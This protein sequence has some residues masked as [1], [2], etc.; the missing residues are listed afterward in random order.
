MTVI[1]LS[2][3]S[4]STVSLLTLG[5]LFAIG[6]FLGISQAISLRAAPASAAEPNADTAAERTADNR[7]KSPTGPI[8]P[9]D[10]LKYLELHPALKAELIASEQTVID[11]VAIDFDEE[12]TVEVGEMRDYP[13]GPSD[14]NAAPL[15]KIKTLTDKDGDGVYET[16]VDFAVELP[17]VTGIQPWRG[18]VI[19]TYAGTVAYLRDE[20]GDGRADVHIPRF[21]GLPAENSQRRANHPKL[22]LDNQIYIANGLRGGSVIAVRPE[23][24]QEAKEVSI[25]GM[26][27]RF[28]PLTGKYEAIS[29]V[30]QFGLTFDDFG[31]RFVCS[32]RNPNKHIV[33]EDRY[34]KRNPFLAVGAV[35]YD[36]SPAGDASRVFPIADRWITS[37]LHAGQFTSACG[38][39]I[40]RGNLLPEEFRGNSFTCEA[41]GSLMHR[42][43]LSPMGATFTSHTGRDGIEFLASRDTWFRSV[44]SADGPDG[45]FYVVDMYRAV[46]EHPQFMPDELK[47]RPDLR[48]GDDR[49]RLYRL[50]PKDAP[51]YRD[52]PQ[53]KL[54]DKA[55]PE[56]LVAAYE[57]PNGWHRST[58]AR[59]L[60]EQLPAS[61]VAPL[62]KMV[63]EGTRP[64]A[65]AQALWTLKALDGLSDELLLKALGDSNLRVAE[66]AVLLSEPHLATNP[67][68]LAAV[69]SLGS[70][71]D[72][73]LRFQV[74]LSLGQAPVTDETLQTLASI[75][76]QPDA[77]S[78]TQSAVLS[79]V[80]DQPHQ[81][82][83]VI[84]RTPPGKARSAM[85][86]RLCEV[87]GAR[88]NADGTTQALSH[89]TGLSAML[90]AGATTDA[91]SLSGL[92]GL[93]TGMNRRGGRLWT[94]IEQL[95]ESERAPVIKRWKQAI[96]IAGDT[97][98]SLGRRREAIDLLHYGPWEI[99][100]EALLNL[101]KSDS[102][103]DIRLAAVDALS[104]YPAPEI[105]D[106]LMS[107]FS[108]STP[109]F[110]RATVDVM[111]SSEPRTTQLLAAIAAGKIGMRI[112]AS[113]RTNWSPLPSRRTGRRFW[114]TMPS[115]SN[116]RLTR[117]AGKKSSRRTALPAI[118]SVGWVTMSP[119]TFPIPGPRLRTTFC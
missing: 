80:A 99:S 108:T 5:V 1:S 31:N 50:V 59:L 105:G 27:F 94:L 22:G 72:V 91:E 40:Y 69:R 68:L 70:S 23:W 84:L 9:D 79:S 88:R 16:A 53:P 44:N 46:I 15:S 20:D 107:V 3:K 36:V 21:T 92:R 10:S 28:D 111:L 33:L 49:G 82:L 35:A 97:S 17:F 96:Q 55:T 64:E 37:N 102:S 109:S 43:V 18:G 116:F 54:L 113:R 32:N 119:R 45:A 61:A 12:G 98:T 76:V 112:F 51:A 90:S 7:Q 65:R 13:P 103:Q 104:A 71:P 93:A 25:S 56:E 73:R 74:A 52:R 41:T 118:A 67:Q 85:L 19:A 110:R 114:K 115:A 62:Q 66:Q 75:I 48:Y 86:E 8:A 95:P 14:P 29:G 47:N 38:V 60:L 63:T 117:D 4:K 2:P 89:L 58:A 81:L 34:L 77:D 100:G 87:I 57:N 42:D 83:T 24:S 6:I 11:P 101:A 78:W 30:G 106:F 26:D 39:H